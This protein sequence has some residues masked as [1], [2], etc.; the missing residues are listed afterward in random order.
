MQAGQLIRSDYGGRSISGPKPCGPTYTAG[1][2]PTRPPDVE[3]DIRGE[4]ERRHQ[5]WQLMVEMRHVRQAATQYDYLRIEDIDDR[6][7]SPCKAAGVVVE[8]RSGI[9]VTGVRAPHDLLGREV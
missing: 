8:R 7:Q 6:G 9:P 4:D 2:S 3:F 1:R 5:S